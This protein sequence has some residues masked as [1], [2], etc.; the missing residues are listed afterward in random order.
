M[1]ETHETPKPM[2][3]APCLVCG[4]KPCQSFLSDGKKYVGCNSCHNRTKGTKT[5]IEAW[6]IWNEE[7][8]PKP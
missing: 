1:S 8:G 3:L 6:K 7:N 4:G 5:A 2:G